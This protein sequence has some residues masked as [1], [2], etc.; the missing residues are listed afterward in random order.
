M[1][2]PVKV[3]DTS[4]TPSPARGSILAAAL[5]AASNDSTSQAL[6]NFSKAIQRA[7]SDAAGDEAQAANDVG[8]GPGIAI[9]VSQI[10]SAVIA[11]SVPSAGSYDL[12]ASTLEIRTT[13][14]PFE[15]GPGADP[16]APNRDDS[17]S[18]GSCTLAGVCAMPDGLTATVFKGKV[19]IAG[20]YPA[21]IAWAPSGAWLVLKLNLVTTAGG[22]GPVVWNRANIPFQGQQYD[23]WGAYGAAAQGSHQ[24]GLIWETCDNIA[25]AQRSAGTYWPNGFWKPT[26]Q[27]AW[28]PSPTYDTTQVDSPTTQSLIGGF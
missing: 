1:A 8:Y 25:G 2:T 17:A 21:K 11:V 15:Y 24:Q 9:E 26:G 27:T 5:K 23:C 10:F 19:V 22:Q 7:Y 28:N 20:Q 14:D 6:G 12:S 18:L 3:F 16:T 4:Y 13:R